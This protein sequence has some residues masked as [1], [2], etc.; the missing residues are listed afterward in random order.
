M[1]R[2]MTAGNPLRLIWQ[3]SVPLV[4][5]NLFQQMYNMI[6]TIIVGR[7][8]GL[9]SLTAVGATSSIMFLIIGFCFGTCSGMGVPVAQQFGAKNFSSMRR[10]VM[11]A[12]YLS[13]L[14]AIAI[15]V[16]MALLCDNILLWMST[17]EEL[18]AQSYRYLLIIFLGLP[19]TILYNVT[20]AIIRALGDSKTPFYFLILSTILNIV[21]DLIFIIVFQMGVA[22]AA[23]ATIAAQA[24]SGVLC[25]IYMVKKYEILRCEK[26]ERQFK[27]V[28]IGNLVKISVPMG[29]Q[30]SITAIG[31]I[32][33][34]SA[35][36]TLGSV[37]VSAYTAALKVKQLAMCPFDA[38]ATAASTFGSQNLGAGQFKRIRQGV[39]CSVLIALI[40][41]IGMGIVLVLAGSKIALLF[42]DAEETVVLGYVQ[43][44]LAFAGMFFW[45]L[46]FLNCIRLA[47]QGLGYGAVAMF[48]GCSELVARG[49][50]SLFAIPVHGYDAV[51]HTDPM[52]WA[53][54]TAVVIPLFCII[55]RRLERKHLGRP[56]AKCTG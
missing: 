37:F 38:F 30:F 11:N 53:A 43:Q 34:Q 2:D 54:A 24:V 42:V 33:L 39:S 5:G 56:L 22:G 32:M 23:L 40:Y 7:Y 1:T 13:I 46:A 12:A 14:I 9:T 31:S 4:F 48:A 44:Q 29:L 15:T 45:L 21:L 19:F 47:I 25:L 6:D 55:L 3:F 10:Y 50:M 41:A 51:C 52:A 26:E 16:A 35:V 36:N 27:P 28:Y 20:S 49:C 17:P 18:F 8:L